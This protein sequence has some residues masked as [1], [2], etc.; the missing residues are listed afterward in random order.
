MNERQRDLF[1][2][3]WSRRRGPGGARIAVRGAIIG[4]LGGAAFAWVMLRG[5]AQLPGV[6]AYD[7]GGQIR[8]MLTLFGMSVPTFAALGGA[9]AWRVWRSQE[10]MYQAIIA[11]GARVPDQKPTL[12]TADRGPMIAVIATVVVIAG[13]IAYLIWASNTGNL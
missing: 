7:I 12:T 10:R 6:H 4:A 11:S 2:Y 5:G 3:Q 1:L 9:L 8:S 13:F